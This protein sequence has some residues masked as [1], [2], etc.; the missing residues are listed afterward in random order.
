[1][2]RF[3]AALMTL[4]LATVLSAAPQEKKDTKPADSK[5]EQK[6]DKGKKEEKKKGS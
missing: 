5:K 4:G 6:D 2:K 3:F 1:M